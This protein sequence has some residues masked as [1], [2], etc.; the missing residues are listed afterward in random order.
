MCWERRLPALLPPQVLLHREIAGLNR[1][2]I[3]TSGAKSAGCQR[4][5]SPPVFVLRA[6]LS[7]ASIH[8]L[9]HCRLLC[10]WLV[11]K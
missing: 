3:N 5:Y 9:L 1:D 10:G 6:R 7:R 8:M 11:Q 2:T 4:Y